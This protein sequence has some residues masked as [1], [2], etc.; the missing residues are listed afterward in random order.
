MSGLNLDAIKRRA[1]HRE[2]LN[3]GPAAY[4]DRVTATRRSADDVPALIAAL[5]ACQ[6]VEGVEL[7]VEYVQPT[8][9]MIARG[10]MVLHNWT[11]DPDEFWAM[12]REVLV[13]ALS[14]GAGEGQAS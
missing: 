10:A 4:S 14:Q 11:S 2:R 6:P 1:A 8:D 7:E 12:A 13:A 9:D 5:E 3:N